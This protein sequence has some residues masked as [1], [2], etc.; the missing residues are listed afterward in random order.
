MVIKRKGLREG[1]FVRIS[2]QRRWPSR[3]KPPQD[4]SDARFSKNKK[5]A[6]KPLPDIYYNILVKLTAFETE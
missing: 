6:G 5:A 1:Q 4:A 2:K 3:G